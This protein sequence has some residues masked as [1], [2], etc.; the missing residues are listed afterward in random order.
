MYFLKY[1]QQ[2][3]EFST[4]EWQSC[5]LPWHGREQGYMGKESR[6]QIL[7]KHLWIFG[8]NFC[9]ELGCC[10]NILLQMIN[11]CC[12]LCNRGFCTFEPSYFC[13]WS[14]RGFCLSSTTTYLEIWIAWSINV[15]T[16]SLKPLTIYHQLGKWARPFSEKLVWSVLH[17]ASQLAALLFHFKK[18]FV[19]WVPEKE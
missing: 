13:G 9:Q 16:V 11:R 17:P 5:E 14:W 19:L 12:C 10:T 18:D 6:L 7:H 15:A 4:H 1:L 2:A 8:G 3:I